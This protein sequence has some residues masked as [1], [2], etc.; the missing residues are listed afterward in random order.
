MVVEMEHM[1]ILCVKIRMST[2][3][4]K[5]TSCNMSLFGFVFISVSNIINPL[6]YHDYDLE[7]SNKIV[8]DI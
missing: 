6:K 7:N 1:G 3:L 8:C 4:V 5:I 2:F